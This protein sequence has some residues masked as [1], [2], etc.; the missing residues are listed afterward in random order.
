MLFWAWFKN[1]GFWVTLGGHPSRVERTPSILG[2][3]LDQRAHPWV[4]PADDKGARQPAPFASLGELSQPEGLSLQD[5]Y[6]QVHLDI[7]TVHSALKRLQLHDVVQVHEGQARILVE[8]FRR[9]LIRHSG[10]YESPEAQRLSSQRP[11]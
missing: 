10:S 5:L 7:D 2:S 3:T 1:R 6:C 9:W 11:S 8:L 4:T